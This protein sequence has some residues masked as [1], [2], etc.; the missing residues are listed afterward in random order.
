ME[1]PSCSLLSCATSVLVCTPPIVLLAQDAQNAAATRALFELGAEL[2]PGGPVAGPVWQVLAP[3][4]QELWGQWGAEGE[5]GEAASMYVRWGLCAG[6]PLAG[7][8]M[9]WGVC[10]CT[11]PKPRHH[12]HD[13]HLRRHPYMR[14]QTIHTCAVK[15]MQHARTHEPTQT[16][17]H[18]RTRTQLSAP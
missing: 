1:V 3:A 16:H 13:Q 11:H 12:L 6:C 7:L 4:F 15:H 8:G 14:M 17:V 5:E 18:S 10:C 9:T 2:P